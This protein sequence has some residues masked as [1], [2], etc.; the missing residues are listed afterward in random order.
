[1]AAP[2][3]IEPIVGWRY[4]RLNETTRENRPYNFPTHPYRLYSPIANVA[5][6]PL[7]RFESIC[8]FKWDFE[9]PAHPSPESGCTCG[10]YAVRKLIP[11]EYRYPGTGP[12]AGGRAICQ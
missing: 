10:V 1:M 6:Q 8:A 4:W 2:D 7:E 5:R 11:Y 3:V 12:I 9:V